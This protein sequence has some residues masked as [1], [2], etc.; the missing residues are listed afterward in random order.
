MI[1]TWGV[2]EVCLSAETK[3]CLSQAS[4]IADHLAMVNR[5]LIVGM[6]MYSYS[7]EKT[8]VASSVLSFGRL[9]A[10]MMPTFL[11]PTRTL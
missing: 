2:G 11:M 9:T 8:V 1:I 3:A 4:L 7:A 10:K 5:L 6:L